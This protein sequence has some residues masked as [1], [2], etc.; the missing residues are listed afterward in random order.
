MQVS[1][2][3][4]IELLLALRVDE[5]AW[6]LGLLVEPASDISPCSLDDGVH[7][8]QM[9]VLLDELREIVDIIEEGYP[10]IVGRVV[11]LQF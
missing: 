6:L 2:L 7:L 10:D 3:R 11:S 1:A 9:A 4:D 5:G 8:G